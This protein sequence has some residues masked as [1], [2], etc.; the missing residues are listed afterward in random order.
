MDPV[1]KKIV[2]NGELFA[3]GISVGSVIALIVCYVFYFRDTNSGNSVDINE[4][5]Y[6]QTLVPVIVCLLIAGFAY[7]KIFINKPEVNTYLAIFFLSFMSLFIS[8][9]AMSLS[10]Y[11]VTVTP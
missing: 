4:M 6:T 3:I 1:P 9:M 5:I 11:S 7:F 8:F 10:L 2:P